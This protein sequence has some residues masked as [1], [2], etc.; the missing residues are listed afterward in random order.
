M[1]QPSPADSEDKVSH[2][3][4]GAVPPTCRAGPPGE[5]RRGWPAF[6]AQVGGDGCP[7][8]NAA[9]VQVL[10]NGELNV[11]EWDPLKDQ[12]DEVGDEKGPCQD[13]GVRGGHPLLPIGAPGM[14]P[15]ASLGSGW[16]WLA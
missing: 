10:A 11:E 12:G 5:L 9:L 1:R 15:V 13:T 2:S 3:R 14:L 6:T 4:G 16:V 7:H 8:P